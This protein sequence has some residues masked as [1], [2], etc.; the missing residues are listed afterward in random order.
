VRDLFR[1]LCRKLKYVKSLGE[2]AEVVEV[3]GE[4]AWLKVASTNLTKYVENKATVTRVKEPVSD[5]GTVV[6]KSRMRPTYRVVYYRPLELKKIFEIYSLPLR[7]YTHDHVIAV[8]D[9][10]IDEAIRRLE[11]LGGC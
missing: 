10:Q 8:R 9:D 3:E 4:R 1:R 7:V 2:R 11:E 6:Y 5:G